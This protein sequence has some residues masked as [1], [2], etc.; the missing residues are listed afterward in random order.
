MLHRAA[1][2]KGRVSLEQLEARRICLIKPSALGDVVQSLPVLTALR[3][4]FPGAHIAWLVNHTYAELLAGHP[5]LNEVITHDRVRGR[6][7]SQAARRAWSDLRHALRS[8]QFDLVCDL[9]GLM[10]SGLMALATGAARRVGLGDSREAAAW[11]Y[12][13][14]L[15]VPKHK[16]SAVDR[17][18]LVPEAL[19]VGATPKEFLVP[20]SRD[21]EQWA[22]R[23]LGGLSGARVAIH[24]GARWITK[25]WPVQHFAEVARRLGED[26]GVGIVLVG[27]AEDQ[28]ASHL[29]E[30]ATGGR[31]VNL[32]GRT[33]LRQLAAVLRRVHLLVTND[34]GPM[35]LAAAVGTRV[36][37]LF[38]CT[39][40]QRARPYGPGHLIFSTQIWC[41]ASY[42][43]RCSRMECMGELTPDR[44]WPAL[45]RELARGSAGS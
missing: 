32:V 24:S 38:T 31:A 14:V 28:A 3:R 18:W 15:A 12:T 45:E 4:R 20:V 17:Y 6:A 26:S 23:Q 10:R 27:G 11:F 33:S 21:E 36:A 39:S 25:R 22:D 34:S 29:I 1:R 37:A 8:R 44:V 40:P 41:A 13:D 43:K 2:H 9:Q 7:W 19:G 5:H 42:L 30:R 16:R 35:H